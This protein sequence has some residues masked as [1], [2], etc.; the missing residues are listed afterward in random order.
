MV[1]AFPLRP[2][3]P[4]RSPLTSFGQILNRNGIDPFLLNVATREG[5]AKLLQGLVLLGVVAL[6]RRR[7]VAV[8]R[9]PEFN[10]LCLTGLGIIAMLVALPFL[11]VDYGL[12]RAFQQGLLVL[13]LPAV[14]GA[15][16]V[17]SVGRRAVREFLTGVWPLAF[18]A[19]STG[20]LAAVTGGYYPQLHLGNAGANYDAFYTHDSEAASATWIR[21]HVTGPEPGNHLT[22]DARNAAKLLSVADVGSSKP[23]ILPALM[24]LD[25]YVFVGYT[26]TV[27]GTAVVV[28][29]NEEVDY[30]YP[31]ELLEENKN[32]IYSTGET[33]VFR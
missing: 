3:V 5:S 14:L 22:A 26:N 16:L 20:L 2:V 1:Q 12:L 32:L 33:A 31:T 19:S 13:S 17:L 24:Q 18:F 27:K 7:P 9:D 10:I 30:Y 4:T 28:H 15:G 6:Y 11:S 21:A 29:G 23:E 25:D 8:R